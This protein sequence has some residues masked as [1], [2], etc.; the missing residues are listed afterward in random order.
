MSISV[1]I[2]IDREAL[3]S[4][5]RKYK[6]SMDS[7]QRSYAWD[8]DNVLELYQD[9]QRAISENEPEYFLGSIVVTSNEGHVVDGQQ[10][11]AT[12]LILLAAMRD[13]FFL[14]GDRDRAV[15][16][17]HKYIFNR[18]FRSQTTNSRLTLN[19]R[20]HDFFKAHVL[21][22][23]DDSER[24]VI[25]PD[26]NRDSHKR[27]LDA[28][29]IAKKRV[30]YITDPFNAQQRAD[31]LADWIEYLDE[32]ARVIWITVPDDANAYTI[33]ETLNDRGVD[34]STADLLKVNIF[35]IAGDRLDEAEARW[36]SMLGILETA[37]GEKLAKTYIRHLWV[38]INGPTRERELLASIKK[39]LTSEQAAIS[40]ANE[41]AES[42]KIYSAILNPKDKHWSTSST[43]Q[44]L[45]SD[46]NT[47]GVEQIRPL[48]LAL[49]RRFTMSETVKSLKNL[50][51]WSVRFLIYGSG[52]GGTLERHYGVRARKVWSGEITT[53]KQLAGDMIS[54]VPGN[55]EFEG[56][57]G[58]A[59]VSKKQLARFYLRALELKASGR[60]PYM[61][62]NEDPAV[63]NLEHILPQV[64]SSEWGSID[65]E[66]AKAFYKRIGNLAITEVPINEEAANCGFPAKQP[67]LKKSNFHLTAEIAEWTDWGPD[68]IK[69]R[70][71][72]LAKLAVDTW[73][74]R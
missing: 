24:K 6:L 13:Y 15:D 55:N 7:N 74:L 46:L 5:L 40:L 34:L 65:V 73:P 14:A 36:D 26:R 68:Q 39:S 9:I 47:L 70:Q 17:E 41:L 57:F 56:A 72:K 38:A 45:I 64:P 4:A 62:P 31:R 3:A 19:K 1:E 8:K 30:E 16:I 42:A 18:D 61:V 43:A 21:A 22:P 63:V 69:E 37:G 60:D 35:N 12:T 25:K 32:R 20:D 23:P 33:F 52:G 53:A 48:V 66:T 54:A 27:I 28:A 2:G 71:L 44:R 51:S 29:A 10:R 49:V 59:R 58:V 67:L 50:V 11:L